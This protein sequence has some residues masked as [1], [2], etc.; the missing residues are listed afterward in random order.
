MIKRYGGRIG[1]KGFCWPSK[2]SR[3]PQQVG[4]PQL[5]EP[6]AEGTQGRIDAVLLGSDHQKSIIGAGATTQ[7][8]RNCILG[9]RDVSVWAVPLRLQLPIYVHPHPSVGSP[10]LQCD[11]VPFSVIQRRV[12]AEVQ[13]AGAVSLNAKNQGAACK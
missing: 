10:S 3:I 6:P 1:R 4:N 5:V 12:P 2:L 13:L 7:F 11:V 9:I 8:E